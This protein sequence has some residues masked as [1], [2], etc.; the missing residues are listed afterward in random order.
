[1]ASSLP[2][3]LNISTNGTARFSGRASPSAQL[4]LKVTNANVRS[5]RPVA[6]GHPAEL[7]P[8]SVT[9]RLDVSEGTLRLPTWQE[10]WRG[11]ASAGGSPSECSS[12]R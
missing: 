4:N 8:V 5:P 11:R 10:R 3:A 12:N 9:A 7:L 6:A 1:M 2:D